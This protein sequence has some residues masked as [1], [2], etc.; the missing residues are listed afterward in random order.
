MTNSPTRKH[1][2]DVFL[3]HHSS[4]KPQVER[5]AVRLEDE[6]GLKPF[7]DKW[8][9]VPGQPW[10]EELE[11]AL[12]QSATCAVFVGP[13][14]LGAWENEEM[15]SALD[16]RVRNQKFC[17]I[18]VLLP[19]ANPQNA[20]TLPRFLRRLTWVDFRAGLDDAEAFKRL[21]AGIR[22]QAPGRG[23]LPPA[24]ANAPSR[25][26][27][28]ISALFTGEYKK[29]F[30]GAVFAL[31]L[32]TSF[33]SAAI[34]RYKL[35]IKSPAFKKDGIYEVPVGAVTIKWGVTKEQW[36]RETDISDI[37]FLRAHLTISKLGDET[38][39]HRFPDQPGELKT[40][41]KPGKYEVR[42]DADGYQ[43]TETIALQVTGATQETA[44]LSGT[45]FDQAGNRIQ[46]A[47]VTIDEMLGMKPVETST[48]GLFTITEIPKP[49]GQRV[50][51]RVN[52]EGHQS[53]TEDVV[54][55]ASPPRVVLRREK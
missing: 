42:I 19:G 23:A 41:L 26:W 54:L 17:V 13:N 33:I 1:Q 39:P 50:R 21:V 16:D 12:D 37:R 11:A 10:Q 35:Q 44:E 24:A 32:S 7:L 6:A 38:E 49:P 34:P 48:D 51:I 30:W 9:L 2:Y 36:F 28:S 47:Q 14:G 45:V 8:H 55:G 52:K 20:Q 40:N 27:P 22:K 18:P 46:G 15:R 53:H 25:R 5:L 31:L 3:S 29:L 43:R 4:D